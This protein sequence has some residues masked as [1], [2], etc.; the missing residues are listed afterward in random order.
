MTVYMASPNVGTVVRSTGSWYDVM[1]Q[2]GNVVKC[3][4][5]GKFKIAGI[6]FTNP[7]AVGDV[8][9]YHIDEKD[10]AGVIT[11]I[12]P[13]KNY[14]VRKSTNL[15]KVEQIIAS[16]ID[17]C[18]IVVTINFPRTS[19]GFIDRYLTCNE[20]FH[21]Q[22]AI[23]V[24]K[25]DLYDEV[26]IKRM[27]EIVAIYRNVGYRV[28]CTSV[29][30][31]VGIEELRLMMKDKTSIFAGHSGVGKSALIHAVDD[32]ID[33]KIGEISQVHE[34]GKHT[35]TFASMY[36]LYF[37]GSI[38]DTPGIKEFGLSTFTRGE[39]AERFPEI[40]KIQQQCRFND[41]Q[42]ISEPGCAVVK[43]VK[44]GLIAKERYENYLDILNDDYFDI[45]DYRK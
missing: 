20:G 36:P 4:F 22:S 12:E 35:T 17:I 1:N 25:T 27:N 45:E 11:N 24:N 9:Q 5:R 10:N 26:D 32:N 42:H 3:R 14:I 15:S 23:V 13:R 39:I 2:S 21:I 28:L 34:K 37:G 30:E 19:T 29:K 31:N 7:I 8:V 16:N 38:I 43:A 44:A 18:F 6:K 41:C 40:R 33:V